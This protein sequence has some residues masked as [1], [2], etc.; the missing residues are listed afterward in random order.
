MAQAKDG[1]HLTQL[2][3]PSTPESLLRMSRVRTDT[4]DSSRLQVCS[5]LPS[6]LDVVLVVIGWP[7]TFVLPR[8]RR[9]P[10]ASSVN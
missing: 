9:R 4:F 3:R 5:S 2:G 8:S 6:A 1:R 10:W 7:T